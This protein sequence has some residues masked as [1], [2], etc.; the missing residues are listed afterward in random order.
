MLGGFLMRAARRDPLQARA[1]ALPE[2]SRTAG[3]TPTGATRT[4]ALPPGTPG[5][6]PGEVTVF[7]SIWLTIVGFAG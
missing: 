4:V 7:V 6:A 1:H 3:G 5:C 2:I